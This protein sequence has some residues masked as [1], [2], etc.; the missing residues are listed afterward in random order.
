MFN[1]KEY[2]NK[3]ETLIGEG[4]NIKGALSGSGLLKI[5][6]IIDGNI[7]WNDDIIIG[8]PSVC[9]GNVSCKNITVNGIIKGNITCKETLCIES[10]GKINGDIKVKNI[11][12]KEGGSIEGKCT[13]IDSPDEKEIF[14]V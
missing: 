8:C 7:I 6:G 14:K 13:M 5:D 1:E 2:N 12:I 9:T 11:S 3:I 4:C 10:T